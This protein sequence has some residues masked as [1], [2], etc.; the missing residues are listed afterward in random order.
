M[1][2]HRR[3]LGDEDRLTIDSVFELGTLYYYQGRCDKAE[4]LLLHAVEWR[5]RQLGEE[6]TAGIAAM[7]LQ[8][9]PAAS[10]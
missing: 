8:T 1:E 2:I 3:E 4:P 5:A 7:A 9:P 6:N 10:S